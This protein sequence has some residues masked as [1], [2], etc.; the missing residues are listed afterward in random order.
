[1]YLTR[2]LNTCFSIACCV[3]SSWC[4]YYYHRRDLSTCLPSNDDALGASYIVPHDSI[5]TRNDRHLEERIKKD[6]RNKVTSN[7]QRNNTLIGQLSCE[8]AVR[9]TW[10]DIGKRGSGDKGFILSIIES[11]HSHPLS[12][13]PL[14]YPSYKHRTT[15]YREQLVQTR[16]HREKVIPYSISRRVLRNEEYG[17]IIT[18]REYYNQIRKIKA[19]KN[20]PKIIEGILVALYKAGF[21]FRTRQDIEEDGTGE[22]ISRKLI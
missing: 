20:K 7:R 13:D 1:V 18:A 8:W 5:K 11:S 14:V 21:V 3:A 15:E 22:V 6:N 12:D 17:L 4:Y 9:Y 10:K 2:L 16:V 19:D